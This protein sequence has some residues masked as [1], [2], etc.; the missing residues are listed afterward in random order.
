MPFNQSKK[1]VILADTDTDAR[2]ELG[3][4]LANEDVTGENELTAVTLDAKAFRF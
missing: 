4:A 2:V 1:G 3:A